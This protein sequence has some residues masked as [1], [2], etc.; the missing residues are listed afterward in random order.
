MS[1]SQ[2]GLDLAEI[3]R[4]SRPRH[5]EHQ[6]SERIRAHLDEHDGYVA[7]SGGKDSLAVLALTLD[8][9]PTVPVCF[10]D[11][12]LEYPETIAYLDQVEDYFGIEI[13]TYPATPS[14]LD[15]LIGSGGWDHHA[16]DHDT[17]DLWE[18]LIG[19]PAQAAHTDNGPGELWGVRAGESHGRAHL[20]RTALTRA[21]AG[22]C[23]SAGER[24]ERHGGVIRRGD[25]TVAYGPIW[26]WSTEEVWAFI[27]RRG[28][29][30]NPVYAKLAALG[31]GPSELRVSRMLGN[32]LLE[33]GWVARLRQGWPEVY[34][35]LAGALPRLR[36][37]S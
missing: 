12:G 10:F 32:G 34:G 31:A 28:L 2:P 23:P 30:V 6:I 16:V 17:P 5:D 20:Y 7:F 1:G 21:C 3:R 37:F 24:R 19:A 25:E 11:S 14:L 33:R 8:A 9:D 18:T 29:P 27:A 26:D 36:E 35:A 15:L 13:A 22:C 4:A